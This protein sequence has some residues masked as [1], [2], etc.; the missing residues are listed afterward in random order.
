MMVSVSIRIKYLTIM[1]LLLQALMRYLSQ[2]KHWIEALKVSLKI[3]QD[4]IL[5]KDFNRLVDQNNNL[6]N[7]DMTKIE[8]KLID[9]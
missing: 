4:L 8:N 5:L 3:F 7:L 9:I 6:W 2:I 1:V